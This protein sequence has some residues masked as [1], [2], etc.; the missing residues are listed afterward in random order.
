MPSGDGIH[1]RLAPNEQRRYGL[2]RRVSFAEPGA[3]PM[4][5]SRLALFAGA[6]AFLAAAA[7]AQQAPDTRAQLVSLYTLSVAIDSCGD[8]DVSD[9]DEDR[10]DRAISAAE[11]K[12]ALTEE[13]SGTLY[14]QLSATADSDKAAFCGAV[15]P[16]VKASIEKLPP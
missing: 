6:A 11:A 1:H 15:G 5:M 2:G 8:I 14:D 16:K 3:L 7:E 13:A 12:L 10:L 4:P 9:A